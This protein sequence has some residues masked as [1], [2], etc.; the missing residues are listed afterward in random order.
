M[1]NK[2]GFVI[3]M[4]MVML[5]GLAMIAF[6]VVSSVR[7]NEKTKDY[8]SIEAVFCDYS[9]YSSDEDGTTY[10]LEYEYE[11]EGK[12]YYVS[13]DY[14]TGI[15]PKLGTIKTIKYNPEN[16]S[17]AIITGFGSNTLLFVIGFMFF[18]VPLIFLMS[19]REKKNKTEKRI[20][21]ESIITSIFIG[22]IF[23]GMG[24]GFYYLMCNGSDSLSLASAFQTA[25][26]LTILPLLFMGVGIYIIIYSLFSSRE[27][28]VTL[29]VDDVIDCED[30]SYNILLSDTSIDME[31]VKAVMYKF[32]LYNTKAKEIFEVGKKFNINIY[33]YG[34]M[35]EM[36]P[37]SQVVQARSLNMF[38][39]KDFE[40]TTV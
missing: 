17:E 31:S 6:G 19:N 2:I 39:D 27:K 7:L 3:T 21:F 29:T 4:V 38:M 15:V 14:G 16:P 11:V 32:Y 26:L 33:K 5:I 12:K 8:I 9:E 22:V 30:G 37:V 34:I 40:E 10:T 24:F 28:V 18:G 35:H 20:K 1:K 36:I 25:G 13:T 23:T